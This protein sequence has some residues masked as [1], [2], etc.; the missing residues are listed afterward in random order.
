MRKDHEL[1]KRVFE[2]QKKNPL[3]G[4]WTEL[5]KMDMEK[6][7]KNEQYCNT[8]DKVSAKCEVKNNSHDA[9]CNYLKKNS[10]LNI[11]KSKGYCLFQI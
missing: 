4:D 1:L 10:S 11:K 9:A 7:N 5:V 6:C 8:L 2:A 3:N